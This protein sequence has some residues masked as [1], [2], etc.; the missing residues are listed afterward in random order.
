MVSTNIDAK[1]IKL[2]SYSTQCMGAGGEARVR[3][4]VGH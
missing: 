1:N 4:T 3:G 2:A